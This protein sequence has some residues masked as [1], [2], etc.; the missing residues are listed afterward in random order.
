M[1]IVE[2]LKIAISPCPND[3]FAFYYFLN[4][5]NQNYDVSFLDIEELNLG[6]LEFKWDIVKASFSV[7]L[8]QT[9]YELLS[10]G[11]AIGM[12][13]G[14]IVVYS[15]EDIIK[16]NNWVVG[17][18]GKNTTANFLW[19]FYINSHPNDV[20]KR[21]KIEKKY[22]NFA[23]IMDKTTAGELD[24]GVLIHEGR[25]VY[26]NHNLKLFVDLGEFWQN[27]TGL[28]I[29][30]GGIFIKK[31][32]PAQMKQQIKTKLKESVEN[33]LIQKKQNSEMY[34]TTIIPYIKKYSQE[35]SQKV[36]EQHIETYVTRDTVLLGDD[37]I[38][39]ITYFE[40]ILKKS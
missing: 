10:S 3:T 9:G 14:P 35:N 16:K 36:I 27:K 37:A 38:K 39:A 19:N 20:P 2:T 7:G 1:S 23:H 5:P 40:K 12:G 26:Q 25:F 33:A 13:V 18:P 17:L 30:L 4:D 11:S 29:P 21:Q 34:Q 22:M 8:Q 24:A 32:L 31:N 6:M 15:K 28:P